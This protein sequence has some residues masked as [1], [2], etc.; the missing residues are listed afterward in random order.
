MNEREKETIGKQISE[1]TTVA[2]ISFFEN[3]P[4]AEFQIGHVHHAPYDV[5]ILIEKRPIIDFQVRMGG[6]IT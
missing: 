3:R 1:Q 4:L 2:L 5:H 6:Y